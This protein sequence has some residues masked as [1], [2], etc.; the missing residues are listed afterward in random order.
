MSRQ[1]RSILGW[2]LYIAILV[3]LIYGTPKILSK[4]LDTQYPMAAITSGSMWP[5]LKKGDLIF[6]KGVKGKEEIQVGDIVVYQNPKGFTIHRVV[7]MNGGTLVTKGDANNIEDSPIPYRD[8]IGKTV[9]FKDKPFR[10]PYVGN[11]SIL[12]NQKL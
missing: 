5:T 11:V 2:I 8:L 10:M 3:G 4:V 6:I 7:R 1:I 12:I 9:K